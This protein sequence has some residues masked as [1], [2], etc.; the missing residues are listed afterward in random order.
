MK[1]A[2][3]QY[4]GGH[5]APVVRVWDSRKPK[6]SGNPF[7]DRST[8][9]V[10]GVSPDPQNNE[11]AT[12]L[13]QIESGGFLSLPDLVGSVA[14]MQPSIVSQSVEKPSLLSRFA[15]FAQSH[16][17]PTHV[18][19]GLTGAL[20]E[21]VTNA[22]FDAPVDE[23]GHRTN[24]GS[25]PHH[26]VRSPK[27][28]QVHFA[29]DGEHAAIHVR[30]NYGSLTPEVIIDALYCWYDQRRQPTNKGLG[31]F[32]LL[33]ESSR[34]VFNI[35]PGHF[36]EVIILRRLERRREF[37]ASAPTL[38]ICVRRRDEASVMGRRH[39]RQVVHWPAVCEYQEA[40]DGAIVMDVSP[41]GAFVHL[42]GARDQ[43]TPGAGIN[44]CIVPK[45]GHTPIYVNG[46]V[47][48][49]GHSHDHQCRGFGVEFPVEC[50][51]VNR[52]LAD[53]APN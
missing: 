17:L 44:L 47:R 35:D 8:R 53:S 1:D 9:N 4:Q 22:I 31:L 37:A 30:D 39:R 19:E 6:D 48:W 14:G 50:A 23:A 32:M 7:V 49:R 3:A 25:P 5:D 12:T 38:N 43:L 51:A 27:P 29:V 10:L 34:L 40:R 15:H 46:V 42:T 20:D 28:I 16:N 45:R 2:R 21:L 18:Q 26:R 24:L 41:K 36:T 11:F 52:M 13:G 33:Q